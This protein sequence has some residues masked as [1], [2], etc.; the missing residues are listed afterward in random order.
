MMSLQNP[1]AWLAFERGETDESAF[2]R[3]FWRDGGEGGEEKAMGATPGVAGVEDSGGSSGVGVG[4]SLPCPLALGEHVER[5]Y[6][7]LP[8]MERV[9]RGLARTGV[10]LHAF[11]NYPDWYLRIERRLALS[12]FLS[13]SLVSCRAPLGGARK[14]E[15][16]AFERALAEVERAHQASPGDVI[17]VDDLEENVL[18]ARNAGV[19]VAILFKGADELVRELR[20]L[21]VWGDDA[22]REAHDEPAEEQRAAQ[23]R[24]AKGQSASS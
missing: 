24:G 18:A 6:D 5:S 3:D 13:W 15:P 9:L 7:F 22:E 20:A 16:R 1:E 11:S 21:G 19:G 23:G 2:L 8:G 10:P 4:G 12:R 14:P 17:F